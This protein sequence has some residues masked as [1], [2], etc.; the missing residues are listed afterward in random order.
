MTDLGSHQIDIFFWYLQGV[1][2]S[3]YAIGGAAHAKA[4]AKANSVGYVPECLDNTF[5][6]YEWNT[7]AGPVSVFY[8]VNLT[9]SHGGFYE[10][11]KGVKGSMVISEIKDKHAMFKERTAEALEWEDEAEIFEV[12]G[13]KAMRFDPLKSRKAKGKMDQEGMALEKDMDKPAHQ[14]HLENFIAAIRD[15]QALNCPP[16]VGFETC[17][18]V[19][20]ANESAVSSKKVNFTDADFK[21]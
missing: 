18:A 1:P 16:E 15:G 9:S 5:A 11:F 19:I 6:I 13:E 7:E 3:V 2:S 10:V 12:G 17:V 4:E 14:P 21:A 8:E 20:K